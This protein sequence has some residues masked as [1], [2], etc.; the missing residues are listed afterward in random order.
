MSIE[1]QINNKVSAFQIIDVFNSVGWNKETKDIL[2]AFQN[3]YYI[4]A[5]DQDH[6]V[7][8]ARAISDNYYYTG[9]FDVITRPEYQNQGIARTMVKHLIEQFSGTYFFLTYTEG[10]REFYKKCGFSDNN[11]AMWIPKKTD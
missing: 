10:N 8:F 4:T 3:S 11:R 2:S 7:G 9:I 6:L 5:Y 1:Y